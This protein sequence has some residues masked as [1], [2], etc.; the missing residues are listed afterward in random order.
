M[1]NISIW[2]ST[3]IA[4][5]SCD[6]SLLNKEIKRKEQSQLL[7]TQQETLEE[8]VKFEVCWKVFLSTCRKDPEWESQDIFE[9]HIIIEIFFLDGG[10]ENSL[11]KYCHQ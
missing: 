8:K 10:N 11:K 2:I 1:Q 9:K 7:G 5:I 4:E 3:N 6:N